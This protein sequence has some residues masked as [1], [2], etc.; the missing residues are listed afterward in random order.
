M[1]WDVPGEVSALSYCK[2]L[3]VQ[4]STVRIWFLRHN[5]CRSFSVYCCHL[6]ALFGVNMKMTYPSAHPYKFFM[7]KFAL[8][9]KCY[10]EQD[11]SKNC[12]YFHWLCLINLKLD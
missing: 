9:I 7:F 1:L 3:I 6:P 12:D 10:H 8:Y 5:C 11:V 4:N 2:Y